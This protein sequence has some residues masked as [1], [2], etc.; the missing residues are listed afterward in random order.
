M[1][2]HIMM[3]DENGVPICYVRE[4]SYEAGDWV[5]ISM[6]N[7]LTVHAVF[8]VRHRDTDAIYV[9]GPARVV[10]SNYEELKREI[11]RGQ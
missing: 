1:D 9:V 2:G 5:S 4:D 6:T 7:D 10:A 11:E 8:N 3:R